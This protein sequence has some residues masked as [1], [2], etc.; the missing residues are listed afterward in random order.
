M[1]LEAEIKE[2]YARQYS[3]TRSL[4]DNPHHAA[5]ASLAF[6][7]LAVRTPELLRAPPE[8]VLEAATTR[9]LPASYIAYL[10][11]LLARDRKGLENNPDVKTKPAGPSVMG[12]LM[13]SPLAFTVGLEELIAFGTSTALVA[14]ATSQ[15]YSIETQPQ[16]L[17][18][19]VLQTPIPAA[20]GAMSALAYQT[21]VEGLIG[22]SHALEAFYHQISEPSKLL[23][24]A[25]AGAAAGTFARNY[26]CT[27]AHSQSV[28]SIK[29]GLKVWWHERKKRYSR[30]VE[31]QREQLQIP[32]SQRTRIRQ[33]SRLATLYS[34]ARQN[35]KA[36]YLYKK[37]LEEHFRDQPKRGFL[38]LIVDSFFVRSFRDTISYY[39]TLFSKDPDT[40]LQHAINI[41]CSNPKTS[42]QV[43]EERPEEFRDAEIDYCHAT[44][45]RLLGE[46]DKAE[47]MYTRSFAQLLNEGRETESCGESKHQVVRFKDPFWNKA[48]VVKRAPRQDLFRF[49][50]EQKLALFQASDQT[51]QE[52]CCTPIGTFCDRDYA[53]YAMF[54]EP[55]P[56][57]MDKVEDGTATVKDFQ[58]A[59]QFMHKLHRDF[60]TDQALEPE[61]DTVKTLEDRLDL[62]DELKTKFLQNLAPLTASLEDVPRGIILDGHVWNWAMDD[63][64]VVRLDTENTRTAPIVVDWANLLDHV[65]YLTPQQKLDVI[66]DNPTLPYFSAVCLRALELYQPLS[67]R[68]HKQRYRLDWVNNSLTALEQI[69]TL[70]GD[71]YREHQQEYDNLKEAFEELRGTIQ[72]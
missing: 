65:A 5:L 44:L 49:E 16:T 8:A 18:D 29:Q 41:L 3:V 1:S 36:T 62:P 11:L 2:R 67:E 30:A 14:N 58:R 69:E 59:F 21:T 39:R 34:K 6:T 51:D 71:N 57:L 23:L 68:D 50:H 43:L 54:Y 42:L 12:T 56:L 24:V 52:Q 10:A 17:G 63:E 4:V 20:I 72:S 28:K 60:P 27:M 47:T 7:E 32:S 37:A 45:L 35:R 48:I 61:R 25:S 66:G 38:D 64:R 31:A 46:E 53:Y 70:H 19:K 55:A 26:A 40:K 13:L 33:L 22:H 9:I 15:T